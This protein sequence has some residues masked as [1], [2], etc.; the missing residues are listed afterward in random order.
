[1]FTFV[2][3]SK[4]RI[5]DIEY[6]VNRIWNGHS[7]WDARNKDIM[8]I[9]YSILI[10]N[11]PNMVSDM[12]HRLLWSTDIRDAKIRQRPNVDLCERLI[13]SRS[14]MV[15]KL[16]TRSKLSWIKRSTAGRN[17]RNKGKTCDGQSSW[18]TAVRSESIQSSQFLSKHLFKFP[19]AIECVGLGNGIR[20]TVT[21][22]T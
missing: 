4:E 11:D 20:K 22:H 17:I 12:A 8:V 10:V 9:Y 15:G 19:V 1:M 14:A 18:K 16:R 6:L 5:I 21:P 2:I 13:L 3:I 7:Q